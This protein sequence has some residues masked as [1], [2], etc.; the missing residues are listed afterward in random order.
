L[1][2][3]G[4]SFSAVTDIR[5]RLRDTKETEPGYRNL[6]AIF[7]VKP[8]PDETEDLFTATATVLKATRRPKLYISCGT[9][10]ARYEQNVRLSGFLKERGYD[11]EFQEWPGDH[12][13]D[14]WDVS[15]QK[16]LRFFFGDC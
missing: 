3:G 4:A 1:Y 7:G 11:H 9:F 14:F 8:E 16:A 10:D 13:W 15:I 5:W 6:Q 2:A 12:D